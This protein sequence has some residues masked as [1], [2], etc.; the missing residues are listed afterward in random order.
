MKRT[1]E[2]FDEKQH[3]ARS[4]LDMPSSGERGDA[5]AALT[6]R[7]DERGSAGARD[8]FKADSITAALLGIGDKNPGGEGRI[9]DLSSASDASAVP[10]ERSCAIPKCHGEPM[11]F[12]PFEGCEAPV[13]KVH[14]DWLWRERA[15]LNGYCA[16]CGWRLDSA[17]HA[18]NCRGARFVQSGQDEFGNFDLFEPKKP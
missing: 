7:T 15:E 18:K 11:F 1:R 3:G 17:P 6:E 16:S 10:H 5:Q 14:F 2:L 4:G 8:I 12:A 13:C 9:G